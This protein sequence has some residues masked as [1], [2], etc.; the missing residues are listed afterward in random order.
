MDWSPIDRMSPRSHRGRRAR[1][2]PR[3]VFR[4]LA[5]LTL[6]IATAPLSGG[7][8]RPVLAEIAETDTAA[9]ADGGFEAPSPTSPWRFETGDGR[10]PRDRAQPRQGAV[11]ARLCGGP[12]CTDRLS[13]TL[14]PPPAAAGALL[15]VVQLRIATDKPPGDGCQDD[16]VVE[17]A[18]G[19]GAPETVGRTCEE[20]AT[21]RFVKH[22]FDVTGP[23]GR[24]ARTGEPLHLRFAARTDAN[25]AATTF[26]L[27]EVSLRREDRPPGPTNVRV[28]SSDFS[29]FSEPHV[30][31]DPTD[32]DRLVGASKAFTGNATYRF[33]VGTFV[34][35]DGGRTWRDRGPLPGLADYDVV[36]DPVVAFGPDGAAYVVVVGASVGP[37]AGI[38][39]NGWGIFAYRSTDG[40]R[41]FAG[42]VA[43]DVGQADDKPW[44]AVDRSDGPGRGTV[45]VVWVDGCTT[46]LSRS[47]GGSRP[48]S[49]RRRLMDACAG[50]QVAVGPDGTVYV[51]APATV[52]IERPHQLLLTI[53]RDAGATF[54]PPDPVLRLGTMPTTLE[55]GF[56]A[57]TLPQ[58]VI[59]PDSGDLLVVW[60]DR[61]DGTPDVWLSRSTDGGETFS[62]PIR[63]NRVAANDQFQ[64]TSAAG[65]GGTVVVA[66]F[67]RSADPDNRLADVSIARSTDG[68]ATFGPAVRVS[69][70][71]FDPAL[72][73]PRDRNGARFFGDYQG[74]ALTADVAVPFWNDPRDGLQHIYA[75]RIPIADIPT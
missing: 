37:A 58:L 44:L 48:F 11:S 18:L 15:L 54:S 25:D 6:L 50:A 17:V 43:V 28:S 23:A 35:D 64:P 8:V 39:A 40:G 22:R 68:G 45:Y 70:Q 49:P 65:Q 69:T 62:T 75:A 30:A 71:R 20:A 19:M 72:A 66:W 14:T 74:L 67:D 13:Q 41:A 57:A 1:S 46:Y 59:A 34:S 53:S 32:P 56:R 2:L 27:D 24:A 38:A 55:G 16:L 63:V 3:R 60:N 51:A 47:L 29:A 31:V 42:P 52:P 12:R 4:P 5:A 61:R 7:P 9:V 26:W 36:S 73:A 21:D 10:D 33:R